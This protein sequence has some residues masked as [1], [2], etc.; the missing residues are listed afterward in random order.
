MSPQL[1]ISSAFS[2]FALAAL[3]V[4]GVSGTDRGSF[5]QTPLAVQAEIPSLSAVDLDLLP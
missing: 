2:V 5:A 3:C 4:V 1:A